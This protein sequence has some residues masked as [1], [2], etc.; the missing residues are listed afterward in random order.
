MTIENPTNISGSGRRVP[1]LGT[2]ETGGNAK[3]LAVIN[4]GSLVKYGNDIQDPS[5]TMSGTGRGA[6]SEV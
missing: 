5:G 1:K 4:R 3:L 2:S 6:K